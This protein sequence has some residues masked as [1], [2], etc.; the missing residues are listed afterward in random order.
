MTLRDDLA[1]T[2]IHVEAA[3]ILAT[4]RTVAAPTRSTVAGLTATGTTLATGLALTSFANRFATVALNTGAVLPST[5]PIGQIGFV[6]NG[7]A[8]P[9]NLYPHS[10]SASINGGGAGAA[11]TIAASAANIFF[12]ESATSW[13]CYTLAIEL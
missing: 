1:G 2:G 3:E 13:F 5:F 7:G 8:N 6:H 10:A 12:K 4:E 11:V 9:L